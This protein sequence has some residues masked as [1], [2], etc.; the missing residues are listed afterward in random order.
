MGFFWKLFKIV[1][2]YVCVNMSGRACVE[3]RGLRCV[4]FAYV[5]LHL[6]RQA[7]FLNPGLTGFSP[8]VLAPLCED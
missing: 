4:S 5:L 2:V 6:L 8:F 3:A 1:C 7:L